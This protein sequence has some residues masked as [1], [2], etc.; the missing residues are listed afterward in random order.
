MNT[1]LLLS[2]S[3]FC[4]G[5]HH[6]HFHLKLF[7]HLIKIHHLSETD[8]IYLPIYIYSFQLHA[9]LFALSIYVCVYIYIYLAAHDPYARGLSYI[10][11]LNNPFYGSHLEDLELGKLGRFYVCIFPYM[12]IHTRNEFF[13]KWLICYIYL[14]KLM[15]WPISWSLNSSYSTLYTSKFSYSFFIAYVMVFILLKYSGFDTA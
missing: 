15:T 13:G 9:C 6:F 4:Y 11:N 7:P 14:I 8:F 2:L 12:T 10:I 3:I 5:W 1:N